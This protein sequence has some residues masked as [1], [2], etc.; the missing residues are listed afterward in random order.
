MHS[1]YL[2]AAA[3]AGLVLSLPSSIAL[4]QES[5][6]DAGRGGNLARALCATCH[7]VSATSDGVAQAG[8]PS[9]PAIARHPGQTPER[10]A[11]IIILPHPPMPAVQL[12]NT[13]LR[14]II[15]YIGSL[16]RPE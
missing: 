10:L 5:R 12:T 2:A 15:A 9:F 7:V 4:S 3:A 13:E 16:N 1:R 6:G 8:I 14:D 11:A